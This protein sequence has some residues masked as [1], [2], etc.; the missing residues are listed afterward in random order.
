MLPFEFCVEGPPISMQTRNRHQLQEWKSKIR[1]AATAI[2]AS[3]PLPDGNLRLKIS[4]FYEDSVP[5]IDVDNLIKPIQ[6]AL[7]GVVYLDDRQ[8]LDTRCRK[9]RIDGSF[10]IRG[11]SPVLADA[12]VRGNEFFHIK[13]ETDSELEVLG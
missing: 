5:E 1:N 12:F 4:Y 7:I 11:I 6:D 13:I 10:R 3:S 8:I 9:R 2:W